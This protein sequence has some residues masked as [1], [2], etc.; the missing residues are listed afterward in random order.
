MRVCWR[1][2]LIHPVLKL[3]I[4]QRNVIV[5]GEHLTGDLTKA[6]IHIFY[7]T[8][9]LKGIQFIHSLGIQLV[10][11]WH[12]ISVAGCLVF[13]PTPCQKMP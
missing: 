2:V 10:K 6:V 13:M 8:V 9:Y 5:Q 7:F 3:N 1:N 4:L 11:V 12:S